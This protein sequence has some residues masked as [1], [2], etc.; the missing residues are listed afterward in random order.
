MMGSEAH[1]GGRTPFSWRR[2]F[3]YLISVVTVVLL[4]AVAAGL[5][6]GINPLELRAAQATDEKAQITIL[7][8][9]L[10]GT[11]SGEKPK[12]TWLPRQFQEELL[13]LAGHAWT[14]AATRGPRGRLDAVATA[15][16][17]TGWF[18]GTPRA[19]R[20]SGSR[21]IVDGVWRIPAAVVRHGGR[22][23]LIS[24]TGMPMPAQYDI[25]AANLRAII[26][27]ALGP[28]R[29]ADARPDFGTAWP[30]E[31]IAA[32]LELLAIVIDRPWGVQVAAVDASEYS[33]KNTLT[34]VTSHNTRIIWG[35]RPSKPRQ[36]DVSTN[37]KLVRLGTLYRDWGRIDAKYN[38]IDISQPHL[39]IDVRAG[40]TGK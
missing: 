1:S 9:E 15:L 6:L 25:G 27:P 14:D 19:R 34:I 16:E 20:E 2:F 38:A 17:K 31:D 4:L 8:P 21:V 18:V 13:V 30:G 26:A 7:W 23:H 24:W 35:G 12:G 5:L 40:A 37:E 29:D 3:G 11:G 10:A 32:S 36:G 22:D 33:S 39:T 28:P